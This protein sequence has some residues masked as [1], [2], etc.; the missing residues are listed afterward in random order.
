MLTAVRHR[1]KKK[2]MKRIKLEQML[3]DFKLFYHDSFIQETKFVLRPNSRF[4]IFEARNQ[5]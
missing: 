3:W 1:I 2:N 4:L 5:C